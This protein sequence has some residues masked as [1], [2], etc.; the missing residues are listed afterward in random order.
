VPK[1]ITGLM[2]DPGIGKALF[3]KHCASGRGVDLKGGDK[4]PPLLHRIYEPSHHA[5]AAFQLAVR[6]GMRTHH[7]QFGDMAPVPQTTPDD[8]AHIRAYV[9]AEQREVGIR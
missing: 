2:P 3:E 6:N 4:G 9:R 7:W 8:V 5:D 1:S